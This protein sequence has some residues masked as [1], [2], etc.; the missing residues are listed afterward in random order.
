MERVETVENLLHLWGF[1]DLCK[2]FEEHQITLDILP[3]LIQD[4]FLN[5]IIPQYGRRLIFKKKVEEYLGQKYK[6]TELLEEETLDETNIDNQGIISLS[7]ADIISFSA[8]RDQQVSHSPVVYDFQIPSSSASSSTYTLLSNA[9]GYSST[10]NIQS[11]D[12]GP[13]KKRKLSKVE[14][15][16]LKSLLES[17]CIGRAILNLYQL[18]G[19]LDATCQGHLVDIISTYFL[20]GDFERLTNFHFNAI[21]DKII[22]TFP[23][24][25]KE[26]YYTP[27]IKKRQSRDNKP[28]IAKGK[29]VDKYRNKLTFLRKAKILPSRLTSVD[30]EEEERVVLNVDD[31]EQASLNWLKHNI[32]PWST[33]DITL[34]DIYEEWTILKQPLGHTLI[35][36]DFEKLF[37]DVGNL[38]Y[39]NWDVVLLKLIEIRKHV[40]NETDQL[41]LD[42][43]KTDAVNKDYQDYLMLTLL[44]SLLPCRARHVKKNKNQW[45]PTVQE[46]RDGIVVR[47]ALPGDIQTAIEKKRE[48][49]LKEGLVLQPFIIVQG[50]GTII[51]HIY[52]SVDN[53]LYIVPSILKAVDVCFR[54]YHVFHLKYPI[55][56]EHCWLFIQLALYKF[57]T[58]W[59]MPIPNIFDLVNKV[60]V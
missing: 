39:N 50:T 31:L 51:N 37:P 52:V 34:S 56:A 21:C 15:F 30:D 13:I 5:D 38:F 43:L 45:K 10:P 12:E 60:T 42:I 53:T 28:G 2:K 49:L 19:S 48:K 55:E 40:L 33:A 18:K 24:E 14:D 4:T 57:K 25:V 17:T 6:D 46:C 35:D 8:T 27:P 22:E 29:L 44:A 59:D 9:S 58:K 23:K 32:E 26:A 16:N 54:C 3:S 1:S 11:E 7:G 36:H 41:L 47:V 20:T